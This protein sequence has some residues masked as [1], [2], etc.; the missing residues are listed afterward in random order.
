MPGLF[1]VQLFVNYHLY[2]HQYIINLPLR[3]IRNGMIIKEGMGQ[4]HM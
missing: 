2:L 4:F 1:F 3:K